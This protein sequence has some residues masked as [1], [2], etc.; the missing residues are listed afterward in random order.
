V[1]KPLPE[2]L[3][4]VEERLQPADK[5]CEVDPI[6]WTKKALNYVMVSG[7]EIAW[8]EGVLVAGTRMEW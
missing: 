2:H 8:L 5:T 1:R 7:L 4:V 3:E 6:L